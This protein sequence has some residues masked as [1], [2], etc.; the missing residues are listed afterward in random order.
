MD[1]VAVLK[2]PADSF[3][4]RNLLMCLSCLEWNKSDS[5]KVLRKPENFII[6]IVLNYFITKGRKHIIMA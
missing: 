6:L 3:G 5:L 2:D 4:V 1:F